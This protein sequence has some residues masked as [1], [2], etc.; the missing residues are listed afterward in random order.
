MLGGFSRYAQNMGCVG[1]EKANQLQN[2]NMQNSSLSVNNGSNF[3]SGALPRA[4]LAGAVFR[5][6]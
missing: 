4:S 6:L 1:K 2:R 3:I 5:L